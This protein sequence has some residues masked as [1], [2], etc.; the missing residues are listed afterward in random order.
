MPKSSSPADEPFGPEDYGT[1]GDNSATTTLAPS[2]PKAEVLREMSFDE[3]A[4]LFE[5]RTV[6]VTD[7]VESDALGEVLNGEGKDKLIGEAFFILDWRFNTGDQGEFVSL[8]VVTKRGVKY[9]VN[10]G[11]TGIFAQIQK[12]ATKVDGG[13]A[14]RHGLR[15]SDYTYTDQKGAERPAS[16]YYIDTKL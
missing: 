9:I 4:G 3:I 12:A 2:L 16:T 10:D 8:R 7:V 11:S 13:I 15:R 14:C 6:D 5:G 1:V